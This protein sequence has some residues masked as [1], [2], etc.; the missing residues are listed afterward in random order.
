MMAKL[1]EQMTIVER[2]FLTVLSAVILG[3]LFHGFRA[4]GSSFENIAILGFVLIIANQWM[5]IGSTDG[6][7]INQNINKD[8]L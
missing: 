4:M 5:L 3:C 7:L 1:T 2:I 6:I 8:G